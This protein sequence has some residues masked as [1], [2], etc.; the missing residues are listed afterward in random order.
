MPKAERGEKSLL[1]KGFKQLEPWVAEWVLADSRARLEKRITTPADRIRAFYDAML[2]QAPPALAY[3]AT[4]QLGALDA[5]E[6]RLLKLLLSLAEMGP[7]VEWYGKG[8][9]LDG[10][11][12]RRFR[13]VAQMPDN[14]TQRI[15]A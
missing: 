11:D 13:L 10:F 15:P 6:E 1:P 8:E 5:A 14:Q 7:A 4:R 12:A 2:A 3:L 9:T